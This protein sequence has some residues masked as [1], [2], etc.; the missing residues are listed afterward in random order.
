MKSAKRIRFQKNNDENEE[1]RVMRF[2]K[3]ITIIHFI[4]M[5]PNNTNTSYVHDGCPYR[6]K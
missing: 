6:V 3:M 1:D 4:Q 2:V 5:I